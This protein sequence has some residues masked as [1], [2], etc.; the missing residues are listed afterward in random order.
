LFLTTIFFFG[1]MVGLVDLFLRMEILL[2]TFIF[3]VMP[4][5]CY[6]P[7]PKLAKWWFWLLPSSSISICYYAML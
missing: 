5:G 6:R 2:L 4:E 7:P 3:P 1:M